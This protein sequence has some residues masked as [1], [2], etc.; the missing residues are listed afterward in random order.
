MGPEWG[1]GAIPKNLEKG[2][3]KSPRFGPQNGPQ[4]GSKSGSKLGPI[5]DQFLDQFWGRFWADF[6]CNLGR[7]TGLGGVWRSLREPNRPPRSEKDD[8]QKMVLASDC[9]HFLV[10]ETPQDGPKTPRRLQKSV[11]REL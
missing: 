7:K 5:L 4:N 8:F 11:Q 3:P 10:L 1:S 6:G 9:L 2:A